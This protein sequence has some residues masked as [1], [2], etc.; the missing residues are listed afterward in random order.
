MTQAAHQREGVG[1]VGRDVHRRMGALDGFGFQPDA[2]RLIVLAVVVQH[3]FL[4]GSEGQVQAFN[5]AVVALLD[6]DSVAAVVVG[7]GAAPDTEYGPPAG[8]HV[9]GRHL[10]CDAQWVM[11]GQQ[12]DRGSQHDALSGLRQGRCHEQGR[13]HHRK[14]A[15]EVQFRQPGHVVAQ[16]VGQLHLRHHVRVTVGGSLALAAGDLIEN[17]KLHLFTPVAPVVTVRRFR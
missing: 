11:Q 2:F 9:Q 1:A 14:A 15:G 16:L 17:S 3:V 4:P 6:G 12:V 7:V 8:Q 10:L 5:E 13:R